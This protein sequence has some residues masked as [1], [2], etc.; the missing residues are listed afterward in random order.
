MLSGTS[1][2]AETSTLLKIYKAL[3]RSKL[4]YGCVVYGS[5]SK[6]V[7]KALDIV[8]HQGLRLSLGAFR[9][10]P[11]QSIYVLSH[12]PSLELRRERLTL[13]TFFKIKSNS[14]HPMHYKV[15]N[16]IYGSLFSLR[17]SFTPTFGFR[18]GGI[19]RNLN[20]NDFPTLEKV[21]EFPP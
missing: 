8:H 10:S 17:L 5:G 21:D 19:L 11:I 14:S 13:N 9:T 15:I 7:L 12:E 18:V 2:G 16:P 1:Y 4:D 3:I 6:S 20:V